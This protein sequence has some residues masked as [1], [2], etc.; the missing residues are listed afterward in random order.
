MQAL[1]GKPFY[2]CTTIAHYNYNSLVFNS[3]K[4]YQTASAIHGP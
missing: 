3:E 4:K 1:H 2:Y